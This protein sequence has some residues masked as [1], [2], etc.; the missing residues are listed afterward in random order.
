DVSPPSGERSP[1]GHNPWL[2]KFTIPNQVLATKNAG[3]FAK[4]KT[5]SPSDDEALAMWVYYH[6]R[7]KV[8]GT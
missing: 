4:E 1:K 6:K 5:Q 3:E 2:E 8:L 7:F